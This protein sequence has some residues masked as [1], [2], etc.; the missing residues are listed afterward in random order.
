MRR[1]D[2]KKLAHK[3]RTNCMGGCTTDS[4]NR[5]RLNFSRNAGIFK[6]MAARLSTRNGIMMVLS[7]YSLAVRGITR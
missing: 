4:E 5:I 7:Q 6:P 2:Q 1:G 3:F